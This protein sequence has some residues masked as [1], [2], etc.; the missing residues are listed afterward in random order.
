VITVGWSGTTA[1][2]L[3]GAEVGSY[4][5]WFQVE[6]GETYTGYRAEIPVT[7]KLPRDAEPR[8]FSETMTLSF[9]T[10]RGD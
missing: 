3:T 5:D 8:S 10:A 7:V 4:S 1:L 2:T 6:T 9:T